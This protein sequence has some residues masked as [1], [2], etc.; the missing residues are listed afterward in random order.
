MLQCCGLRGRTLGI[1]S[2]PAGRVRGFVC[3]RRRRDR[4]GGT[5][6]CQA[7]FGIL[8]ASC[9]YNPGLRTGISRSQCR[10]SMV[11]SYSSGPSS[12]VNLEGGGTYK[13]GQRRRWLGS[14]KYH[15]QSNVL[16]YTGR[17]RL[18]IHFAGFVPIPSQLE[19]LLHSSRTPRPTGL[20]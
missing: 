5:G 9:A 15:V 17:F 13:R 11:A 12:W 2:V 4:S 7:G 20:D 14:E 8:V 1:W 6:A 3:H 16:D 10:L 18:S 19:R